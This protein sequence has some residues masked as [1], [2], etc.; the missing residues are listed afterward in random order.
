MYCN[1]NNYIL[2]PPL[3]QILTLIQGRRR[4]GGSS[5]YEINFCS[6][7]GEPRD[8]LIEQSSVS[9]RPLFGEV[10]FFIRNFQI[11]NAGGQVITITHYLKIYYFLTN[12]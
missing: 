2:I 9:L 11:W 7:G 5:P 1:K 6:F 12:S 10:M 8:F 3:D 4:K